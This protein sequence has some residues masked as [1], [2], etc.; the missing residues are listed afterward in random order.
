VQ[1]GY[2]KHRRTDVLPLHKGLVNLLRPYLAGRSPLV[3]LWPDS[4]TEAGA[5]MGRRDLAA[6]LPYRDDRGRVLDFH[7]LRHTFLTHLAD[8][9]VHPKV[10]QVLA[11]HSTI[12]LT[13]DRYT[14]LELMDA[15]G[16]LKSLPPL[17]RA[18][19]RR[20]QG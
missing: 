18:A 5:E 13:M 20:R 15:A 11:R 4:W 9:G 14:H 7:G 17:P 6:G 3:P 16:G 2:S 12:T 10:A 8:S 1:A 19:R